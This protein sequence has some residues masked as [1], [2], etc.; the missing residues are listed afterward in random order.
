[1]L[2]VFS[3]RL[4]YA[5]ILPQSPGS[6]RN[7]ME[8]MVNGSTVFGLTVSEA[9]TEAMRLCGKDTPTVEFSLHATGQLYKTYKQLAT[10]YSECNM[11]G[12]SPTHPILDTPD[13][14]ADIARRVQRAWGRY[15]RRYRCRYE[16][17]G[18]R[19]ADPRQRGTDAH[20][21]RRRNPSLRIRDVEPPGDPLPAE[22]VARGPSCTPTPCI[23]RW[24]QKRTGHVLSYP[25]KMLARAECEQTVEETVRQRRPMLSGCVARMEP[26]RLP[27]YLLL[28]G[29]LPE[30]EG[31]R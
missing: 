28:F 8:V 7:A 10:V 24:K 17:Y 30:E 15:H 26:E 22:A 5:G 19:I 3:W 6:L 4:E 16:M 9:K 20:S 12:P 29:E 18:R 1:M 14:S 23:G 2:R 31:K 13:V 21:R 11:G 27:Q 25:D